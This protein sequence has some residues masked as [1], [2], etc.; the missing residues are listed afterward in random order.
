V[1]RQK[2][3]TS[4]RRAIWEAHHRKSPYNG[5]IIPWNEL[6]IDH[7]IPVTDPVHLKR[8]YDL[9]VVD[10]NF[11][12]NGFENLLPAH[13]H[14]NQGKTDNDWEEGTLRFFLEIARSR[15]S[16]IETRMAN[17][18]RNDAALKAYLELKVTAE[19]NE[20]TVEDMF[21][22]VRH[23]A[24]GEVPLR[25]TPGVEG[26]DITSANS[27]IAA[28]LM[29]RRF[30]LGGGSITQF[31]LHT[32]AGAP[33]VVSTANEYLT[34]RERGCFPLTNFEIK[35]MSMAEETTE[36]LKAVRDSSYAEQSEIREPIVTMNHL[37]RWGAEWATEALWGRDTKD[38]IE[39]IKTIADFF[40]SGT[41]HI[42]TQD[43]WELRFSVDSGLSVIMREL[44]RADLDGDGSEE[45]LVFHYVYAPQGSLG[46]GMVAT[47]KMDRE[48]LLRWVGYDTPNK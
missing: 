31:T 8:A 1:A 32:E 6:N 26:A 42:E 39:G 28:V 21:S 27:S 25:I 37:E 38:P 41:C 24:D 46:A 36:L 19:R 34:A 5:E 12:V 14:H 11:D 44:L 10:A 22:Y 23:Q 2:I 29:D 17:G 33:V 45:I 20:V 16:E 43:Q 35:A 40:R 13:V 47:A 18:I 48:G 3:S 9:G 7:V 4:A 15:K 30:A